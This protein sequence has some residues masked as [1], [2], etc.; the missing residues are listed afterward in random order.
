MHPRTRRSRVWSR[1]AL[2]TAL[3]PLFLSLL[4]LM[5]CQ[6]AS[7]EGG[8]V[9]A[10]SDGATLTALPDD[11]PQRAAGTDALTTHREVVAFVDALAAGSYRVQRGTLGRSVEGQEIPYLRIS[12]GEFG[13]D[14]ENRTMAMVFAMQ[15]G[16]EHSGLEGTLEMALELARGDHDDLLEHVDLLVVPSVNPDGSDRYER[17]NAEDVDL[18]RS[19]LILDGVEVE[20]L[21][22][23]FHR[24]EPEVTL[25][26]HEY[27]PWSG[28]WLDRGWIR[29]FDLQIGLATNLNTDPG[30]QALAEEGFLPRAMATLEEAGFTSHNY[31]VG[32]PDGLRWSTTN[33]NDGRQ[34]FAI[35]HTLSFIYEGRRERES[36]ERIRHRA[37]AQRLGIETFLRFLA[38]EGERVRATV[39]NARQ[40]AERGEIREVVLTMGRAHGDGPLV[41]PVEQ[42]ERRDGEWVVVD[43]VQVAIDAFRPVVTRGRVAELPQ[44]YLIPAAEGEVAALL[45][46]HRVE[47]EEL[48]PGTELQVERLRIEGFTT[49]ELENPTRIPDV[50]RTVQTHRTE[51]GDVL[52][53][54][55]QLRGLLVATALEPESMHGLWRY[56]AF[57]HLGEEGEVPILRVLG[58]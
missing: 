13:A 25:D 14:R 41:I 39:R 8:G 3:L 33:I 54:T 26:I 36:G 35:L 43:T 38:H 37:E 49:E 31:I 46:R 4:V 22:E 20:L 18:N 27:F 12:L 17:R 29:L 9:E 56:D 47:M 10:S 16:N 45:R 21:R 50:S 6:D 30:I 42:A 57:S 40:R 48:A 28:T 34:G 58:R 2:D 52:V 24:W 5:G 32:S 7:R 51:P 1:A 23:L 19:H 44:A 15:H 55:A 11:T 53:P